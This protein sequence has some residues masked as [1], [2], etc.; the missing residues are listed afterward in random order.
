MSF[1]KKSFI[2]V[3]VILLF[4]SIYK[5]LAEHKEYKKENDPTIAQYHTNT[6]FTIMHIKV[7]PGDTVLAVIEQINSNAL[8][9]IDVAQV[10]SDFQSI[11]PTVDPYNIHPHT[12]YYFPKYQ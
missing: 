5:D 12:F 9:T 4:I 11:N 7:Q 3:F 10:I 6:D 2:Y 1:M 8:H